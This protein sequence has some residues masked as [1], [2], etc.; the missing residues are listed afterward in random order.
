M[1]GEVKLECVCVSMAYYKG[2]FTFIIKQTKTQCLNQNC[3][4]EALDAES[5]LSPGQGL[6]LSCT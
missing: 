5:L 2:Q 6:S 1:K 4:I 3:P